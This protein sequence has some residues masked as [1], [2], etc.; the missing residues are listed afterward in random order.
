M[1]ILVIGAGVSGLTTSLCL[2]RAGFQV[3][4]IAEKFGLDI[5]STVAGALWEY[6]PAVCGH[7]RDEASL[8]RSKRW[9]MHSYERF[10]QLAKESSTGVKIVPS[11][12]YFR[13]LI[14]ERPGAFGKML[15]VQQQVRDFIQSPALV[16]QYCVNP[17]IGLKDAYSHLS[18]IVNTE[19]YLSWLM[20]QVK[21][22][23]CVVQPAKVHGDLLAQE[24]TLKI[25]FGVDA[26]VNCAGLGSFALC[27]PSM[28]P[29]R[30]VLVALKNDGRQFKPIREAHCISLDEY[31]HQQ[32]MVYIVP[33]GDKLVL[34]G[35]AEAGEWDTKVTLQNYRPAREMYE[36]CL[37]FM[38]ILK[39]AELDPERP[40]RVGLRPARKKNVRLEAEAGTSI[41][42]NYGHGGSGFS[43]SWGCAFEVVELLKMKATGE[44]CPQT[45][46]SATNAP[47]RIFA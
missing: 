22:A 3:T 25:R 35:L 42:H 29:L 19:I 38:P 26:I 11:V 37:E 45:Q 23:G 31:K 12:F 20:G 10:F 7:H 1:R 32:N 28:Y 8:A 39:Q 43:L 6:P 30:G 17:D 5:V 34:G 21:Q 36:R 15:E 13:H 41:I 14:H 9:S 24:K 33:R 27:D 2:Q 44:I 16:S 40:V 18:P 47:G 46:L 4:L